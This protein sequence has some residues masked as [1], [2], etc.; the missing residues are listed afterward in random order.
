[1]RIISILLSFHSIF[2]S[3]DFVT[4]RRLSQCSS[5][6]KTPILSNKIA[7]LE[8]YLLFYPVRWI[9]WRFFGFGGVSPVGSR[10]EVSR[11]SRTSRT[12]KITPHLASYHGIIA[13]FPRLRFAPPGASDSIIAPR[14]PDCYCIV[15]STLILALSLS[16]LPQGF[17]TFSLL[18]DVWLTAGRRLRGRDS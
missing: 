13:P 10:G 18:F 1:M 17:I 11:T 3:C 14:L 5:S 6:E 2:S 16:A 15:S 8:K 7:V 4:T 12:R 9:F